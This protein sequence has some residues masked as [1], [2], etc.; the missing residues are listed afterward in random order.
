MCDSEIQNLMLKDNVC[1]CLFCVLNYKV[2]I[3]IFIKN[4][5]KIK[6]KSIYHR[7]YHIENILN[8]LTV[9]T[10]FDQRLKIYRIF[11][12]IDKVMKNVNGQRKWMTSVKYI[13]KNIFIT[14]DIPHDEIKVTLKY[15]KTHNYYNQWWKQ[16][17]HLIKHNVQ[18][19]ITRI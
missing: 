17:F 18:K 9:N 16:V 8:D 19:V 12:I 7:K 15:R 13:L 2:H 1:F 4:M 11:N 5:Y 6:R 14:I 3:L 10:F